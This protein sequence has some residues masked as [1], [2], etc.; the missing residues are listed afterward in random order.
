M[1]EERPCVIDEHGQVDYVQGQHC[2]WEAVNPVKS[3]CRGTHG[4]PGMARC[5]SVLRERLQAE[6]AARLKLRLELH[7]TK[8]LL[9]LATYPLTS[10][11]VRIRYTNY[12]GETADRRIRPRRLWHG[13]TEW[14][15]EPGFLLEAEDVERRVIRDFAV[16][17][18]ETWEEME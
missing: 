5:L 10:P 11:P 9:Y 15:P 13:T 1:T 7:C 16:G 2:P 8:A 4:C 6:A 14:H 18:I 17:D 3:R 12:R